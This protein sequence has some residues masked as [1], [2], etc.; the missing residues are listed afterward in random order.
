[1]LYVTENNNTDVYPKYLLIDNNI[2]LKYIHHSQNKELAQIYLISGMNQV[3]VL[4]MSPPQVINWPENIRL[5]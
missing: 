3:S 2:W 1:M 5:I 4:A